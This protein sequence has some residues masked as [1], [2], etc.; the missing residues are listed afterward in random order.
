MYLLPRGKTVKEHLD[1]SKLKMPDA[2]QKM[3]SNHFSGYLSFDGAQGNGI[4]GF[5]QGQIVAALWKRYNSSK[6]Q[7]RQCGE[8][9]LQMIFNE[10]Q[11]DEC[12][13]GVYRL[14]DD[15]VPYVRQLCQATVEA[16]NQLVD[17]I[18]VQRL[19]DRLKKERFSGCLRLHNGDRAELIFYSEG[20]ALGFFKDGCLGLTSDVNIADSIVLDGQCK[21]DILK[22]NPAGEQDCRIR[23]VNLEK[24]WLQ[25][26]RELNP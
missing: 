22:E 25:V 6:P 12:L 3:C 2:L 18:D 19:I 16:R 8:L 14:E 13:M 10:V 20:R 11:N 5:T 15:F 24:V 7:D 21:L 4:I 17:L 26:W 23:G 9:A 1:T